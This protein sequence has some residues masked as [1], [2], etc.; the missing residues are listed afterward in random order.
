[1][2]I[3]SNLE[4]HKTY[5]ANPTD[6]LLEEIRQCSASIT[7]AENCLNVHIRR[8]IRNFKADVHYD[9]ILSGADDLT[10]S[11]V[12]SAD[13][14]LNDDDIE[15]ATRKVELANTSLNEVEI[16]NAQRKVELANTSLNEVAI[17][18]ENAQRKVELA[19]TS[20]NEVEIE[21]A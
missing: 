5:R 6:A 19:N 14:C 20:L 4:R 16:E 10:R 18:I 21:N 15:I 7:N 8:I 1:M 12:E 9:E 2:A 11:K 13:A 17:E 3:V